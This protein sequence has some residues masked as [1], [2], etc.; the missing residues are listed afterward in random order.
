VPP[1]WYLIG[2]F[3]LPNASL[4]DPGLRDAETE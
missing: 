1:L 2:S 3:G 4:N